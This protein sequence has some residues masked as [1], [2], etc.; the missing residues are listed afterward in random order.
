[1]SVT[2]RKKQSLPSFLGMNAF[3][4][5]RCVASGRTLALCCCLALSATLG[6]VAWSADA[7]PVPPVAPVATPDGSD[8]IEAVSFDKKVPFKFEMRERRDPFTF[9]KAVPVDKKNIDTPTPNNTGERKHILGPAEVDAKH[10]EAEACYAEAA[11]LLMDTKPNEAPKAAESLLQCDKG[12]EIFKDIVSIADYKEL[13]DVRENLFRLRKAAER[14]RQR[15]DAVRDFASLNIRLTGVVVIEKHSLAIVNQ[16]IVAKG[17][18]VSTL[19]E[20]AEVVVVDDILADQVVFL[21]RGFH[22]AAS[23]L[24][25]AK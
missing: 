4:S 3:K 21:F 7:P 20:S 5:K 24:D 25:S 10:K 19:G 12:L 18:L 2:A 15:Q 22:I 16:K 23:L 8:E 9:T 17:D 14:L 11:R 1:M 6:G 13:Q